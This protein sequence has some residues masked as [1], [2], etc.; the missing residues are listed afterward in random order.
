M[1]RSD[2]GLVLTFDEGGRVNGVSVD[3]EELPVAPQAGG[4]WVLPVSEPEGTVGERVRVAAQPEVTPSGLRLAAELERPAMK[5][6]A[7][8]ASGKGYIDVT[9]GFEATADEDQ[10]F[11]VEFVLPLVAGNDW[12]WDNDLET[13]QPI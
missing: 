11:T 12:F 6:S 9:V 13:S 3:G 5:F 1:V 7:D 2:D 10:A 8:L 4:F